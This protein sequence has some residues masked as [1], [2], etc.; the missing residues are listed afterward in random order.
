MSHTPFPHI[1]E[2]LFLKDSSRAALE[3]YLHYYTRYTNHHNSL[4]LEEK[5]VTVMEAKIKAMEQLD[6]NTWMDCQFLAEANDS[7][8]RC[9]Y[10]EDSS[11]SAAKSHSSAS[12][13]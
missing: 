7:L 5:A 2:F 10:T 3:R 4:K 1:S 11:S 9:R 6:D 8:R 12:T 13:V